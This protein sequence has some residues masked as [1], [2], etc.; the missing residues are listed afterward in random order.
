MDIDILVQYKFDLHRFK[1]RNNLLHYYFLKEFVY[2]RFKKNCMH[3]SYI[4]QKHFLY[5]FIV[6]QKK[7]NKINIKYMKTILHLILFDKITQFIIDYIS[8][9]PNTLKF[10]ILIY[11]YCS[12][13]L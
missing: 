10:F 12:K 11:S 6:L 9:A 5:K 13:I 1:I 7:I 2:S 4:Y 3:I 8:I